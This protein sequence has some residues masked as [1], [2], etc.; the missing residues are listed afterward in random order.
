MEI[1]FETHYDQRSMTAM[2]KAIRK[3]VRKKRSRRS[4]I[5]GWLV[6]ILALVLAFWSEENGFSFV[7][8]LRNVVTLM[9]AIGIAAA[10]IWEDA[11]NGYF[12]RRRLLA[13]TEKASVLFREKEFVSGTGIGTSIFGY[14]KIQ[15]IAEDPNFFVFVFSASH[16]QVYD[17]AGISGGTVEDFRTFIEN[18]TG[19]S[20][21]K[22]R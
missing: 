8:D 10:L 17:K 2:A 3:T 12:A 19:T 11:L 16:A 9:A 5:F 7:P 14:D 15:L 4:H 1:L 13:G 18:V 21:Q 20:I 6:V 22:I